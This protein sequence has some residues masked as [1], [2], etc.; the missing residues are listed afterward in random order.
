M[1]TPIR[2]P[3]FKA[4]HPTRESFQ[5][6][7]AEFTAKVDAPRTHDKLAPV[8]ETVDLDEIRR[9]NRVPRGLSARMLSNKI[10]EAAQPRIVS[11]CH[12][13]ITRLLLTV[14]K[15][16]GYAGK[17]VDPLYER[18]FKTL[19]SRLG[20]RIAYVIVAAPNQWTSIQKWL[21]AAK[22]SPGDVTF[23][24][25][26]RFQFTIWAQDAYVA[27]RDSSGGA[28]LCEGISFPRG[29]DMTIADDIAAQSDIAVLHSY[30]Y[31]QGG[32]VL[33]GEK[34]TL[35]G[36]DYVMRNTKR[37]RLDTVADVL[38]SLERQF[39]TPILP[40]GGRR[41]ADYEWLAA[42]KLSGYGFQPI[43]HIDMYVTPTGVTGAGGK[44]I[45]FLGR[46]RKAKEVVGRWSDV[47]GLD[48]NKYDAF[49]EETAEQLATQFEVRTL[50]LWITYGNLRNPR[51]YYRFY[52]AKYYNLT[53][54][55]AVVESEGTTRRVLLP[56]YLEDARRYGV[57]P[58]VRKALEQAA[59]EEWK[60]LDFEV[61]FMDGL[62]DLAWGDGS[63]HCMTKTLAR[64]N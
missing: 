7:V 25:S 54:N 15:Y 50:P 29:E 52:E 55:N 63:V 42:G 2:R 34:V 22:V 17:V 35:M 10:L 60:K 6:A 61:T 4:Y 64:G 26:P 16:R 48:N 8:A 32:N 40:L 1:N 41:S 13:S 33:G 12:G 56:S 37:F 38:D 9:T 58:R 11:E 14:P 20:D 49:F 44:E 27:L 43:F 53:W 51:F 3:D 31:F 23:V 36:M 21:A 24:A 47:R 18:H 30:L 39:G 59:A 62:E 57:D 46:P 19:L 28:I 45:V 5:E